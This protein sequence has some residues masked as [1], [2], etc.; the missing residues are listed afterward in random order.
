MVEK[1]PLAVIGPL[2]EAE[3]SASETLLVSLNLGSGVDALFLAGR[4][5]DQI[6]VDLGT[7]EVTFASFLAEIS[8]YGFQPGR[9]VILMLVVLFV[10][11]LAER[12]LR[13]ALADLVPQQPEAGETLT[14]SWVAARL[15]VETVALVVFAL[16]FFV[17]LLMLLRSDAVATACLLA[18]VPALMIIRIAEAVL[19][20]FLAPG[21]ETARIAALDRQPAFRLYLSV[22]VVATLASV[23]YVSARLF[24][25]GGLDANAV[26]SYIFVTRCVVS[27]TLLAAVLSNRAEVAQLLRVRRDGT[28]RSDRWQRF[29]G[30]WHLLTA[31][32]IVVSFLGT[33]LLLLTGT[34]EANSAALGG[35]IVLMLAVVGA[36]WVD[37]AVRPSITNEGDNRPSV[38]QDLLARTGVP[39]VMGIA[40]ILLMMV[41]AP[42]WPSI[43]GLVVSEALRAASIQIVVTIMLTFLMW[44]VVNVIAERHGPRI[45]A[46]DARGSRF[47]TIVPLFKIMLLIGLFFV[48]AM[49]VLA[50]VGV[51][52]LPLFAGAGIIGLAIGL[53]SQTLV[54][55]VIS[56]VF[57]LIDDAFR[58]GEYI[59]IGPAKGTVESVSIRSM[60]LRHHTGIVHTIPYGE[61]KTVSNLSRDWVMM[62]IVF[63][64]P[65]DVDSGDLMQ[66]IKALGKRLQ[67]DPEIGKKFI[68]PLKS[69]G[70][71]GIEDGALIIR[72]KFTTR[73]GDQFELR[74]RAYQELL[75]LFESESIPVA[76]RQVHVRSQKTSSGE[77]TSDAA[78]AAEAELNEQTRMGGSTG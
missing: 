13:K 59:D 19:R 20:V 66:K 32:Y 56:G 6:L 42:V 21:S 5:L 46:E 29:A 28:L 8:Q 17:P 16:V 27:V 70:V 43:P 4:T 77:S 44:Q 73:P 10:A 45:Q 76:V 49:S 50:A 31:T 64:V 1:V 75:D 7:F 2:G 38:L 22:L 69:Q 51:D 9:A 71:V 25:Q 11:A 72:C 37:G 3:A 18:I 60:R 53:G 52:I 48:S 65:S 24:A 23:A 47:G 58:I 26:L 33:S 39:I 54:K 68:E 15:A 67:A 55:D 30:V 40:G 63:R 14:V 12:F 41:W 35:F 34:P 61:I 36:I 78:A 62:R 57:F 74:C